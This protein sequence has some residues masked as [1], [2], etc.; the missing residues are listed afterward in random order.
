[1]SGNVLSSKSIKP[2][3]TVL[4][5]EGI[6]GKFA[7]LANIE[8]PNVVCDHQDEFITELF[9]ADRSPWDYRELALSAFF[10]K[11]NRNPHTIDFSR[12][13]N[14]LRIM[15]PDATNLVFNH[16]DSPAGLKIT[17]H[18][19]AEIAPLVGIPISFLDSSNCGMLDLK[20]LDLAPLISLDLSNTAT[21]SL[22][23]L[24]P[25]TTLQEL[26][27]TGWKSKNYTRLRSLPQL[28]RVIV[29][30]PDVPK[31]RD[32]VRAEDSPP[33]ITGS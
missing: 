24:S 2:D 8:G 18:G 14:G 19:V 9:H 29:D 22:G 27:L 26:R 32:A 21:T 12:I 20:L 1:M 28:R 11:Y 17:I 15:N 31:A 25:I 33:Q 7:K 16:E 5:L 30:A 4:S 23:D 13:E 3:A 10:A 6:L